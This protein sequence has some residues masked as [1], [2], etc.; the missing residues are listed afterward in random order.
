[1]S[2][3]ELKELLGHSSPLLST[4]AQRLV[5]STACWQAS[6]RAVT[7]VTLGRPYR[8]SCNGFSVRGQ[9]AFRTHRP[10]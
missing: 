7:F 1:V 2:L 8:R 10:R 6:P 5:P 4:I 9:R 3:Y